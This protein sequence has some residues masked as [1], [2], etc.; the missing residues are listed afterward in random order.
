[1]TPSIN[2]DR[3]QDEIA[4][5]LLQERKMVTDVLQ[6]LHGEGIAISERTL[7]SCLKQ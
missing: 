4:R 7:K 5:R 3:F 1:M 2:I 6:Y